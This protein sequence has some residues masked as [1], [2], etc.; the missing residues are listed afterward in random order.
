VTATVPRWAAFFL[1]TLLAV[2]AVCV[3]VLSH[4]GGAHRQLRARARVDHAVLTRR[5]E[6]TPTGLHT[7]RDPAVGF[8]ISYPSSWRRLSS[9]D[10]Q[11]P[12]LLSSPGGSE[13]LL[14][15]VTR[16]GLSVPTVTLRDLPTLLPLTNRLV[17][18]GSHVHQ[19]QPPAEVELGGL[20]GYG[21]AYTSAGSSRTS[22]LAHVQYF[23]FSGGTL[24]SLVFQ[25]RDP[26]RLTAAGRGFLRVAETFKTI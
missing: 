6:P 22:R 23:L 4:N 1:A 21:Y 19:L 20:P 18:A 5:S 3:V 9:P 24:I 15:R 25:T 10:S 17:D 14:I 7:F 11:V 26:G 12:L 8:S 16:L 13:A 2:I